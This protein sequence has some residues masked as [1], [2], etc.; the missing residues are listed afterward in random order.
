MKAFTTFKHIDSQH[1]LATIFFAPLFILSYL[2]TIPSED[3][4]ILYEYAKNLANHGMITYGG[5]ESPIEGATDFLWMVAIALLKWLGVNEFAAA[6]LLNF[7]GLILIIHLFPT[8]R[9]RLIIGLAILLTSY[10]YASL[11]GFSVILFS[12]FYLLS[13]KL[14]FDKSKYL[15]LSLLL[16]CLIRPDG[17]IWSIGCVMLRLLQ[18]E[19]SNQLKQEIIRCAIGLI[20]PG[21][22]Y[23]F[24]R[25]WYFGEPFPLPFIVKATPQRDFAFLF[26]KHSIISVLT[27]AIPLVSTWLFFSRSKKTAMK[28]LVLL[29]LPI[30]FYSTMMLSQNIGNRFM[31]PLFFAGIFIVARKKNQNALIVF[32]LISIIT[33]AKF[34]TLAIVSNVD[35]ASETVYYASKDL[36]TLSGRMLTTEAGR[37]TYYSNWF[38]EDIQGLNTPRYAHATITENDIASNDYDLIVAYCH[39]SALDWNNNLQHNLPHSWRQWFDLCKMLINHSR[40]NEY[41]IYLMPHYVD[42]PLFKDRVKALLGISDGENLRCRRH[43]LYAVSEHYSQAPALVA[44]LKKHGAIKYTKELN[45]MGVNKI[46]KSTQDSLKNQARLGSND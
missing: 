5:A 21:L 27:A 22:V 7:I 8:T 37:L 3:A 39:L 11:S 29:G 33:H 4:V 42:Q 15:Y 26:F 17:L 31:A 23:F 18:T 19:N 44:I 30:I 34:T 36:S 43:D 10:L 2:Y 25:F 9:E 32:V 13:L 20:A 35:S 46:C 1:I 24:W 38:S 40:E 6:L 45:I 41:E 14:L 28:F 12:A 16:L